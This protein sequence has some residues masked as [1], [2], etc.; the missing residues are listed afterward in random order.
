MT[1][2]SPGKQVSVLIWISKILKR[3]CRS[4]SV[5]E[6]EKQDLSFSISFGWG[7]LSAAHRSLW[8]GQSFFGLLCCDSKLLHEGIIYYSPV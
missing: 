2:A 1:L 3:L 8:T 7:F 5:T 4:E 6:S